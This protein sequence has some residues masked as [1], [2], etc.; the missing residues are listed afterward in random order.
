M[1]AGLCWLA[2]SLFCRLV[3]AC[4]PCSCLA[5]GLCLR[6]CPCWLVLG[7]CLLADLCLDCACWLGSGSGFVLVRYF[8]PAPCYLICCLALLVLSLALFPSHLYSLALLTLS[9]LRAHRHLLLILLCLCSP[10]AHPLLTLYAPS[11]HPHLTLISPSSHPLLTL[12]SPSSTHS[13]LALS[14]LASTKLAG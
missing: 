10:S 14:P 6:A 2:F 3:P 8:P 7:L 1:L 11:T 13:L 12:Y 4:L 9:S 5:P